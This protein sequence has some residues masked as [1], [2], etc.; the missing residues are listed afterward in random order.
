MAITAVSTAATALAADL[1]QYNN[2][3]TGVAGNTL[4]W[5]LRSTAA[6]DFKLLLGDASGVRSFVIQDSAA[7]EIFAVD[8]NG[9]VSL[10]GT[11]ITTASGQVKHEAGGIETDISSVAKGDV[12]AGSGTGSIS[13]IAASGASDGDALMMQADGTLAYETPAV[14]S[15]AAAIAA[16]EGEATLV[17]AGDVTIASSKSLGVDTITEKTAA[18]GV[19]IDSVVLKD[20]LVDG[21]DV[22]THIH[23]W[24]V[25]DEGSVPAS[26]TTVMSKAS[27]STDYDVFKLII[28]LNNPSSEEN[29]ILQFN[30]DSGSNYVWN[31]MYM[32]THLATA[33]TN[34][35]SG[36]TTTSVSLLP[37]GVGDNAATSSLIEATITKDSTGHYANVV[38]TWSGYTA[39]AQ[40]YGGQG[41]GHWTNSDAKITTIAVTGPTVSGGSYTLF[42]RKIV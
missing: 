34:V 36:S 32:A 4:A 22:A 15:L 39:G 9:I 27:I 10:S 16:V 18:E 26:G 23:S 38:W 6:S 7:A 1:N 19:T 3:L 30:A 31:C 21:I 28:H 41:W 29:A 20:G 8:S 5:F 42:G 35:N 17:L 13:L 24:V 2:H 37:S 12:L 14:V 33:Y 25:V 11:N 40:Y